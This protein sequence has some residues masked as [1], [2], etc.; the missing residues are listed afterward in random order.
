MVRIAR[1]VVALDPSEV[2]W[3]VGQARGTGLWV[4]YD[5]TAGVVGPMGSGKSL[6]LLLPALLA[7]PGAALS[8]FTKADD[9]LLVFSARA[10]GGRPGVV[11]DPFGLVPG[12]PQVRWDIIAG[13]VQPMT[14]ERR[15]RA[16]TAGTVA[17]AVNAGHDGAARFYAAEAAKV[18]QGYLHAAAL[19]GAG[20]DDFMGW[21]ADP[22][23]AHEPEQILAHHPA[24]APH[25]AGLLRG[26]LHGDERTTSNTITTVQQAFSL[27]FQEEVRRQCLPTAGERATDVAEVISGGGT[28]YL[29]AR[30][31]P[32]APVAP[33][34]TA[35]AEHVLDTALDLAGA[36]PWGRLAPPFLAVLDELPSIAPLPTL[37]TRLANDR[38]L[39][40]SYIWGAQSYSQLVAVLGDK[41]AKTLLSLTNNLVVFGGSIDATFNQELS[42]LVGPTRVSRTSWSTGHLGGATTQASGED[43]DVITAAEVRR[44]SERHALVLSGTA[45]P[46]IAS[47]SRCIDGP[48]GQRL[49]ADQAELRAQ[50]VELRTRQV[51]AE[52]R[53]I[54]ALAASRQL[55]LSAPSDAGFAGP[56]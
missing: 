40:V 13:C 17:G 3:R 34:M 56:S 20:V 18:G 22:R 29:L 7:A 54:A 31:D 35:F 48:S 41:Q 45:P 19:V 38:A 39:G 30:T 2:G 28:L 51:T 11:L 42:R 25:W 55:G 24:A 8:T 26:A 32:Y 49:L 4:R 5:R 37:Q 1:P 36:S 16:F 10:A 15:A 46:V 50:G 23:R 14:A 43:I 21:I 33:L 27:F 6:D 12:L 52:A 9:L 44:L 47:L 53:Q